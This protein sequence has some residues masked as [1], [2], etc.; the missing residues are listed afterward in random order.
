MRIWLCKVIRNKTNCFHADWRFIFSFDWS[1]FESTKK[2][3]FS[4]NDI[5]CCCSVRLAL[6]FAFPKR[7]WLLFPSLFL[8]HTLFGVCENAIKASIL[9]WN[10][11]N[12]CGLWIW[13]WLI[14]TWTNCVRW[15]PEMVDRS[16]VLFLHFDRCDKNWRFCLNDRPWNKFSHAILSLWLLRLSSSSSRFKC[17]QFQPK[18]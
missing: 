9:F 7:H 1:I 14:V 4:R 2:E 6:A 11:V 13:I 8:F 16:Q 10:A 18:K 15:L 5:I 3:K 12:R 17:S